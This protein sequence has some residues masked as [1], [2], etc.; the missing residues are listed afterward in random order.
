MKQ[1]VPRGQVRTLASHALAH[2]LA[3]ED[4]AEDTGRLDADDRLT[5]HVHGRWIHQCVSSRVHVN[6]VTRHR[7]CRDCETELTVAVD[8]LA[9]T[10]TMRC[11]RCKQGSSTAT[12][13][14]V[15]ACRASLSRAG[16]GT[17]RARIAA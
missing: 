4:Q 11:P 14:L 1:Q 5:C 15:T 9:R 13:R 16:G 17:T 10:V 6:P 3:A 8:E 7:W 12:T 2:W